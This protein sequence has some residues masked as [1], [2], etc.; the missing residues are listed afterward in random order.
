M[1]RRDL[2]GALGTAATVGL[3]GCR[4][5]WND[6]SD[7]SEGPWVDEDVSGPIERRS[8][9]YIKP[10]RVR[11]VERPRVAWDEVTTAV[12]VT[13]LMQPGC[14]RPGYDRTRYDGD[15]DRLLVRLSPVEQ[16]GERGCGFAVASDYY[17]A[18]VRFESS[19]PATVRIESS[20][21]VDGRRSSEPTTAERTVN[22]ADQRERCTTDHPA[23][24]DAAERAHWTCPERYVRVGGA[25]ATGPTTTAPDD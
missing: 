25:E 23:G 3:A 12:H 13:G 18:T 1:R 15:A 24:A 22:R 19:L 5:Y 9:R 4:G 17:R 8:I 14:D 20:E 16:D 21:T 7:P 10:R 11:A 6:T 2:L